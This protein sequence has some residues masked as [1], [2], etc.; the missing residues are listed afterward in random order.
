LCLA[1]IKN[2]I[3]QY[4]VIKRDLVINSGVKNADLFVDGLDREVKFIS[5]SLLFDLK[6][7]EQESS[8]ILNKDNLVLKEDQDLSILISFL[9]NYPNCYSN[10]K[11]GEFRNLREFEQSGKIVV[12]EAQKF[13]WTLVNEKKVIN[14]ITCYKATSP[15]YVEDRVFS[16]E[17]SI[18]TAWYSPKHSVPYGPNG[19]NNLPGLI[20]EIT[21]KFCTLYVKKMDF[22]LKEV[23]IN[24]LN[25]GKIVTRSEYYEQVMSTMPSDNRKTMEEDMKNN[26][27]KKKELEKVK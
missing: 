10:Y 19:Y 9:V 20:M 24:K 5:P 1:Q 8:F 11:T 18:V 16:D 27:N 15:Y 17:G 23:E 26:T 14:G 4:G 22:N 13:E 21:T 25:N 7:N 2:G 12:S 6:F 3:V